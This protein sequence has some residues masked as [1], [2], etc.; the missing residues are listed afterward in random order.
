MNQVLSWLAGGDLRSDGISSQVS[1]LVL[2]EPQLLDDL[3]A[4]LGVPDEV[5]R[6]RTADALEKIART[7]PDLLVD[8]LPDLIQAGQSDEVPMVRWHI[9]MLLGHMSIYP[10]FEPGISEALLRMLKDSSVFVQSWSIV[11]LCIVAKKYP[12]ECQPILTAIS[13]LVDSHSPAIRSKAR[14]AIA[15]LSDATAA[16]PKGWIKSDHLQELYE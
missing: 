12:N 2:K 9:A 14:K 4:G 13:P 11:S 3:L 15:L 6:G 7:R 16:F 1:E 8:P 5:V 10:Q